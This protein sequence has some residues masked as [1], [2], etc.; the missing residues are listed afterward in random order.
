M[1]QSF[2][3]TALS[4]T[5]VRI[6]PRVR[7]GRSNVGIICGGNVVLLWKWVYDGGDIKKT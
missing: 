3:P 7:I 5:S 4:C 6:T 1:G 2:Q